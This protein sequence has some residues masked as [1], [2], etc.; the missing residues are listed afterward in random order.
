VNALLPIRSAQLD[1]SFAR[2]GDRTVFERRLFTW[3]FVLTRTF[4]LDKAPAHLLTAIIQTSSSAMHGEDQLMQRFEVGPDAAVHLTTQG[5]TAVHR[6]DAGLTTREAVSLR[7][8]PGAFLEYLPEPRILFPDAALNQ[9]IDLDCAEGGTAIVSDAFTVHDPAGAGRSFRRLESSTTFRCSDGE[10]VMFDRL[11]IAGLA[12]GRTSG[13]TAF[14]N[15]LL[16]ARLPTGTLQWLA[17][18]VSAAL[19]AIPNLYGA[20]SPLPSGAGVGVRLAGRDLRA[21][22]SGLELAWMAFRVQ[23]HGQPPGLRR[24][25]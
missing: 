24:E 19:T 23:L 4:F 16:K 7:V 1:L 14:G 3:P 17:L 9:T 10:P 2:R 22:R 11:D 21:L 12:G 18:D 5:A 8:A 6:A 20:A 15:I 25:R 13:F